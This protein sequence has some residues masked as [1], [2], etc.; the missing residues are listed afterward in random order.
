M[1]TPT[2][3]LDIALRSFAAAVWFGPKRCLRQEFENTPTGF[4]RLE[5]WLKSHGLGTS[6]RV[7]VEATSTYADAVVEWL[8][9][10]GYTVYLLNP[11]RT[12]CYARCLG[13]RNKTDPADALTIAMYVA[14]HE[15]TPWQPPAPEQKTLRSLTRTRHQLTATATEL[16]N[17]LKTATGPGRQALSAVL[18]EVRSQLAALL[19]AVRQHLCQYPLLAEQVRCLRTMKGVGLITAAVVMAELPPI[20]T[21]SDPRTICGWAGLTPRRWQSGQTEGRTRLSRKG[22]AY[23]RHALYMP[24]LVAKRWN[25]LFKQFAEKLA[26]RGKTKPAILGAISHKMLRI[27]VGMLRSNTNFDPTWSYQKN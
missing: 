6:L 19:R 20:T 3:G 12:A 16:S 5:R 17:Q 11:E 13:Q 7:G 25:P 15:C 26:A 23:L 21:Q 10:L 24:A 9:R 1:N 2:L 14:N 27:I 4:R 18:R 8:H 22:N